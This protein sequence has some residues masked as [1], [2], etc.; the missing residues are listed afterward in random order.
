[1]L[2]ESKYSQP[3]P[4][5]EPVPEPVAE[6]DEDG[7]SSPSAVD[8]DNDGKD[9]E[10]ESKVED[11][12]DGDEASGDD[13]D[14]GCGSDRPY[15]VADLLHLNEDNGEERKRKD[16]LIKEAL[17][18]LNQIVENQIHPLEKTYKYEHLAMNSFGGKL[19]R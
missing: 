14:V 1:L 2:T 17:Q 8:A 12:A 5:P 4:E 3:E 15:C 13:E 11:A 10:G 7:K 16:I 18:R 19:L 9:D 6:E